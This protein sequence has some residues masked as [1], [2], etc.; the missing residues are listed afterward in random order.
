MSFQ[1]TVR[2]GPGGHRYH[3]LRVDGVDM[4]EALRRAADELPDAVAAHA[5]LVEIRQAVDPEERAYLGED[6]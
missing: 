3:T 6:E 4:R 5:D 2:H 1:I